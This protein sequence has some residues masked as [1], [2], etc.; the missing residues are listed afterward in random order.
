MSFHSLQH[1]LGK[2]AD[3]VAAIGSVLALFSVIFSSYYKIGDNQEAISEV[4]TEFR[5]FKIETHE[6]EHEIDEQ[7]S[8][9]SE[10]L[11]RMEG[12]LD[13]IIDVINELCFIRVRSNLF[14]MIST[15]L[16]SVST[17]TK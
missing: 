11:G 7:L 12:K 9:Q 8:S 16:C 10:R 6:K 14:H 5:N 2:W 17:N 13:V 4:K 15:T 3:P 1:L